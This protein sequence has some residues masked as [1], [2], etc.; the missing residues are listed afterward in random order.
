[1]ENYDYRFAA[2]DEA[3]SLRFC[4]SSFFEKPA[5]RP[6]GLAIRSGRPKPGF[7]RHYGARAPIWW[8]SRTRDHR[9]DSFAMDETFCVE[10]VAVMHML[11]VKPAHRRTA[12]GRVLVGLADARERRRGRFSRADRR[13]VTS[14][15]LVNLFA[16]AGFDPIGAIMGRRL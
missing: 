8:R 13:G 4:S 9:R 1:M 5:S 16:N 14:A 15:S 2:R 6:E 12:V 10:P 7:A 11:Y 3:K